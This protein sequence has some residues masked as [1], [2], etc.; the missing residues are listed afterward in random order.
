MAPRVIVYLWKLIHDGLPLALAL[1]RRILAVDPMCTVCGEKEESVSHLVH[2]CRLARG[3][4]LVGPLALKS[5]VMPPNFSVALELINS[6]LDPEQWTD[7]I[8]FL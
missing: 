2:F 3:C 6:Q 5:D 1:H 8:N 7:Y 4:H